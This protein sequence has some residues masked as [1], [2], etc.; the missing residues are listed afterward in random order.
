[1]RKLIVRKITREL[2]RPSPLDW[3]LHYQKGW[4]GWRSSGIGPVVR[5][6]VRHCPR[7]SKLLEIGHG[8][9]DDAL[10]FIKLGFDYT[11]MEMSFTASMEGAKRLAPY[12][13]NLIIG[14]F[15][16]WSP[17]RPYAIIYEKGV[18]HSLLG[19]KRRLAFSRRIA[20]SLRKHGTWIT[21]CGS[22]DNYDPRCPHG[23]VHLSQLVEAVEPFF[24]VRYLEKAK[25]G[26]RKSAFDF[27]AWI[28][29]FRRLG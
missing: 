13:A 5:R 14:D 6:Y 9:G 15:F 21:V 27:D 2:V 19:R 26:L 23:V 4:I 3:D 25:Y 1:M 7:G 8:L 16:T 24:E 22:A 10:D 29:L 20:N 18:F 28:G 11:G 12:T 17:N